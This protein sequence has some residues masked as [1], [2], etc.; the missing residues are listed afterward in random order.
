MKVEEIED[1]MERRIDIVVNESE[2][3]EG[4]SVGVDEARAKNQIGINN[5]RV[6]ELSHR[7]IMT[8]HTSL[9]SSSFPRHDRH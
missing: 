4:G 8:R 7:F 2:W 5:I 6:W 1:W 9:S 3:G